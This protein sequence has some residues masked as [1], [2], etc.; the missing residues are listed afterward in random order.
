RVLRSYLQNKHD[1]YSATKIAVRVSYAVLLALVIGTVIYAALL[2]NATV[3]YREFVIFWDVLIALFLYEGAKVEMQD[4][5]TK[6]YTS[7]MS[8][9]EMI[10]KN[11]ILVTRSSKLNELY[12]QMLEKGSSI[13]L[14]KSGKKVMALSTQ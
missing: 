8:A 5:E 1:Y 4:A 12:K 13:V 9:G 2:V 6:L 3:T 11:Y 14:I 10:S 7:R